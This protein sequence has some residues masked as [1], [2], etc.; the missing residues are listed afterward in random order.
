MKNIAVYTFAVDTFWLILSFIYLYVIS[1]FPDFKDVFIYVH[2]KYLFIIYDF[3]LVDRK[4]PVNE[5]FIQNKEPFNRN[6]NMT[7]RPLIF[8]SID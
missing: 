4:P 7:G 1:P 2:S 8:L 5:T 3:V 6:Q